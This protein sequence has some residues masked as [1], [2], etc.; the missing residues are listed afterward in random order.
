MV[1]KVEHRP[2]QSTHTPQEQWQ[3][4]NVKDELLK[5]LQQITNNKGGAVV[6]CWEVGT[7]KPL[8]CQ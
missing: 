3:S 5:L 8:K 1:L 7:H 4:P 2:Q 6:L